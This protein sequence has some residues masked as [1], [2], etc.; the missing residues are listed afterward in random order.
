MQWTQLKKTRQYYYKC[1]IQGDVD[2]IFGRAQAVFD[3]CDIVSLNRGS[4]SNNGYITAAS[5]WE[6][7]KYGYLIINSRLLGEEGMAPNSVSLGRPWHP[8]NY[9]EANARVAYIN[10]YMGEHISTK[11]WDDMSGFKAEDIELFE[12]IFNDYTVNIDNNSPLLCQENRKSFLALTAYA[13]LNELDNDMEE[14]MIQY[15]EKYKSFISDQKE[16]YLHMKKNLDSY[17]QLKEKKVG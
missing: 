11:G 3:D 8:N 1:E 17:I 12:D 15:F 13:F 4:K 6:N 2:F 14:W 7:F 16:N 5:T 10:C 9:K